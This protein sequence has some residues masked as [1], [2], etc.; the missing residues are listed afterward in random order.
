M[1]LE[2]RVR[3]DDQGGQ[4]RNVGLSLVTPVCD[5]CGAVLADQRRHDEW[6]DNL[7]TALDDL[8]DLWEGR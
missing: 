2:E 8:I 7:K 4:R 5:I 1:S 6:H 3:L